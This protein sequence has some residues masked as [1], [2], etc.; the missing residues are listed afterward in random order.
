MFDLLRLDSAAESVYRTMLSQPSWGPAELSARL[1]LSDAEIRAALDH[2]SGMALVRTS[3][4]DPSRMHAVSP[5]L[6]MEILLARQMADLA[7]QQQR[8]EET[9]AA[10]ARL[11]SE[12]VDGQAVAPGAS[13]QHLDGVEAV[14]D[15]L[16]ALNSQVRE[17]FLT[18]A[19]GGPQSPANMRASRP[20]NERLLNRGVRM[21]T[22]YLDSIRRDSATLEHATWLTEHGARVRTVPS[23]P[24]R[25]IICD[26]R[27]AVIA[28]DDGNTSSGAVVVS[29]PGLITT[30]CTLFESTWDMAEPLGIREP[31]Q[32]S[33]SLSRQQLEVLQLLA[34]GRTDE[35]IARRLGVSQ[36]TARRLANT[37]MVHLDARSRFQA[38]VR[39][40]QRGLLTAQ[41][42]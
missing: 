29:A 31:Q 23:L 11:I 28:V 20:L 19:P 25:M 39:A 5:H 41:D 9:R 42:G 14:R 12:F 21:R 4:E 40:A 6:G 8:V 26:S 18:F 22:I 32:D 7:C 3:T 16:A 10:A 13:V 27:V 36:R 15:Y 33:G 24:N 1:G 38:G 2:L 37:L 17:E 30:L 34:E 35:S